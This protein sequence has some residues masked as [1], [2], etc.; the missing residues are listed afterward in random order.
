MNLFEKERNSVMEFNEIYFWTATISKWRHLLKDD[1]YKHVVVDSLI[2]L[3]NANK[4]K[5]YGFVILPNHVHLIWEMLAQNGK[6]HPYESFLKLT[7]P[8]FQKMLKSSSQE[9]YEMF[10]VDEVTRKQRYWK[11]DPLAV[12]IL[13]KEMLEQKLDYIHNNPLQE[14]WQLV[15]TPEAY[16]YSSAYDYLNEFTRFEFL[17]HYFDR[18]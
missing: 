13:S 6:E 5:V 18:V 10:N 11:R 8:Q 1:N 4:I 12:R 17:C 7:A 16:F 14:H 2:Y 9:D 3:S 15:D